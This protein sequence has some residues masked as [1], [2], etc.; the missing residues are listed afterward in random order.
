[1][2]L[3]E[4]QKTLARQALEENIKAGY[5]CSESVFGA[6]VKS[7]IAG[8]PET[9]ISLASGL[10]AGVGGTGNTCGALVG[11][12]MG[13]GAIY[14]RP[15]PIGDRARMMKDA[16]KSKAV[17]D[18]KQDYRYYMMRR[19][20]NV[21]GDFKKEY[22]TVLCGE[23]LERIGGFQNPGKPAYCQNIMRHA[24]EIALHY[25]DMEQPEA[26]ALPFAENIFGW[27]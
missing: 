22:G 3:T 12:V 4:E 16:D 23:L 25:I 13:L 21:P 7:G 6:L 1:M 5:C 10:C 27:E 9:A 20:N 26:D 24:L 18:P 19:F 11:A 14:G 17:N 2:K 8:L 15:D